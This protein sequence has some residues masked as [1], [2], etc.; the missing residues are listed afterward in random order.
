MPNHKDSDTSKMQRELFEE[1]VDRLFEAADALM[2]SRSTAAPRP[3]EDTPEEARFRRLLRR[4]A[5]ASLVWRLMEEDRQ[6]ADDGDAP[7]SDE[8]QVHE[9]PEAERPAPEDTSA[10]R[11]KRGRGGV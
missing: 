6:G 8:T 2:E 11:Q 10:D 5:T 3:E 9:G 7:E 1:D 4:V